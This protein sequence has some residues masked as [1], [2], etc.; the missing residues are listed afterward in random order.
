M[1]T[2]FT[3]MKEMHYSSG[4]IGNPKDLQA[5]VDSLP[6]NHIDRDD[7]LTAA[8]HMAFG[9]EKHLAQHVKAL[10]TDVRDKVKEYLPPKFKK[11]H[12]EEADQIHEEHMSEKDAERLAQKHVNAA[13]SAKKAGDLKGHAAHAEASNDIRDM[14]LKHTDSAKGIPSGKIRLTAKKLFG[15]SAD[16]IDEAHKMA[17]ISTTKDIGHRVVKVGPGQTETEIDTYNYPTNLGGGKGPI[18][19][20]YGMPTG[21]GTTNPVTRA[22]AAAKAA[23]QKKQAQQANRLTKEEVDQIDEAIKLNSKVRIHDPGKKHHGEEGTVVEFRR[24]LPGVRPSYYTVDHGGTSTQFTR[25][26]I[27]TIKEEVDQIN[28]I[29]K[30]K[31]GDYSQGASAEIVGNQPADKDK[32]RKRTNREKFI[33][34]AYNKY[35]GY[36]VKVPATIKEEEIDEMRSALIPHD[37]EEAKEMTPAEK[38]ARYDSYVKTA[39]HHGKRKLE[40]SLTDGQRMASSAVH[41]AARMAAAEWK[42]KYMKEESVNLAE[43]SA[44]L[45]R[46]ASR[47]GM[48]E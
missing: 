17:K 45:A 35:H 25:E 44:A 34:L 39:K 36:K 32:L 8:S 19:G 13:I 15:E 16:Q 26:N 12:L 18:G 48:D 23:K 21:T 28:E 43:I 47:A 1:K 31:I 9:N 22:I 3:F 30:K 27:K 29:S 11:R 46:R 5:Y 7:L 42:N 41:T 37:H 2:Y 24:G 6:K 38:K 20:K 40:P 10:D 14:I 33:K 4:V